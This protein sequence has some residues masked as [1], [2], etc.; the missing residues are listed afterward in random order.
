MN[1]EKKKKRKRSYTIVIEMDNVYYSFV[2][3]LLKT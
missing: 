1:L 3:K 2:S